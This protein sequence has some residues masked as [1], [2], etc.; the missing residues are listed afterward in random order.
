MQAAI[1]IHCSQKEWVPN[2]EFRP[3]TT[4]FDVK[5]S[6]PILVDTLCS[7]ILMPSY[8]LKYVRF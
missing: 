1:K 3:D 5:F 8:C 6:V 7:N 4:I 2:P